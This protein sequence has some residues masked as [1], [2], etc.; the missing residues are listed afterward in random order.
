MSEHASVNPRWPLRRSPRIK[1]VLRLPWFPPATASHAVL[2]RHPRLLSAIIPLAVAS[3][4]SCTLRL[5]ERE[6]VT[7]RA[8]WNAN[9]LPL[10]SR[11]LTT[12]ACNAIVCFGPIVLKNSVEGAGEQ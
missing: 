2:L 7:L 1:P 3:Q 12:K 5:G 10:Y 8:S 4:A 6:L 9:A 11:L